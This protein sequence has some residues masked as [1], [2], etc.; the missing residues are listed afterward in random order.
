MYYF[1]NT[2]KNYLTVFKNRCSPVVFLSYQLKMI[3]GGLNKDPISF[4]AA[5]GHKVQEIQHESEFKVGLLFE[6]Q[7][8]PPPS[9]DMACMSV[10]ERIRAL[11]DSRSLTQYW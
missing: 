5:T 10:Y 7:V 1:N 2:N 8:N 9:D 4:R 3:F 11:P 6:L